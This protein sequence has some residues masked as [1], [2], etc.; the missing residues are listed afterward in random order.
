[1]HSH[2]PNVAST[3]QSVELYMKILPV[4][5]VFMTACNGSPKKQYGSVFCIPEAKLAFSFCLRSWRK[6]IEPIVHKHNDLTL[7]T[8][9]VHRGRL[10]KACFLHETI[11]SIYPA[12]YTDISWLCQPVYTEF[13]IIIIIIHFQI[14]SSKVNL[15]YSYLST[16]IFNAGQF[17]RI[18]LRE[19][20]RQ[21]CSLFQTWL[22]LNRHRISLFQLY[23]KFS[24][25]KTSREFNQMS[26]KYFISD[27]HIPHPHDVKY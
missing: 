10:Q 9:L 2:W 16:Q 17:L 1:M 25:Y 3:Q 8:S 7:E 14:H 19:V 21:K 11:S 26:R 18:Q 13:I 22:F 5:F 23:Y 12:S 6:T 20:L 4:Q 15:F 27:E 24:S